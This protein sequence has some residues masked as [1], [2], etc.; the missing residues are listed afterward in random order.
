[1]LLIAVHILQTTLS[2]KL[3]LNELKTEYSVWTVLDTRT[4]IVL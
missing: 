1:M 2:N 3:Y 4:I